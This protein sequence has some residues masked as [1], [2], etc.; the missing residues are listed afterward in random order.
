MEDDPDTL[1]VKLLR[2]D[3]DGRA[4]AHDKATTPDEDA[5]SLSYDYDRRSIYIL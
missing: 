5:P 2:D 1:N 4:P 3:D